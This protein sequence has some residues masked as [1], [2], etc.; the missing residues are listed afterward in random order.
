M[1]FCCALASS[2]LALLDFFILVVRVTTG[3][4]CA[5][6]AYAAVQVYSSSGSFV[7]SHLFF[8]PLAHPRLT[9]DNSK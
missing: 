7:L 5:R 4:H 2:L 1:Y 3:N 9:F 6:V 8:W